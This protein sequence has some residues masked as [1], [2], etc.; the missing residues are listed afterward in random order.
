[1]RNIQPNVSKDF[2]EA[3]KKSNTIQNLRN[4]DSKDS[5]EVDS[6]TF[7]ES[8][9]SSFMNSERTERLKIEQKL[10]EKRK[11]SAMKSN[12]IDK[13]VENCDS[14]LENE[15][16][17]KSQQISERL[18]KLISRFY[19]IKKFIKNLRNAT[20]LRFPTKYQM[21]RMY[22]LNDL[23]FFKEGLVL[24]I[25]RTSQ[26]KFCVLILTILMSFFR[27]FHKIYEIIISKF[28]KYF[29]VFDPSTTLRSLWD[30]IHLI[31]LLFYFFKIPVELSFDI[32]LFDYLAEV[33]ENLSSISH[34]F[35]AFFLF[36]DIIINFNTGYYNKGTLIISRKS[37]AKHYIKSSFLFDVISFIPIFLE[38]KKIGFNE[39]WNWVFFIRVNNFFKIFS[40]IE[41]SIHINFK[42]FNLLTLL[43]VVARIVLLSHLFACGW[44]YI[45][46]NSISE[47]SETW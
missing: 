36:F 19:V 26:I 33:N 18:Y 16:N 43:K 2:G 22:V 11:K 5:K 30:A 10:K 27:F 4:T 20:N 14:P 15:A 47:T 34:N 40:K 23:C 29:I 21:N 44:H 1:M 17:N 24:N 32:S 12:D 39:G 28:S 13:K 37:L 41:E 45:S 7:E 9:Q 31:V 46:F 3:R 8:A 35:G 25:E 38:F 42:L 6:F